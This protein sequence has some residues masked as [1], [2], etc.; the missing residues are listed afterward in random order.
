[1]ATADVGNMLLVSGRLVANPTNLAIA[2][3]FGGVELGLVKDVILKPTQAYDVL[4]EEAL[5]TEIMDVIDLGQAWRMTVAAR[6]FDPDLLSTVFPL[7]SEVGPTSTD[8][9][10]FYPVKSD[11]TIYR[12]GTLRSANGVKLLFVPD[13]RDRHPAVLLYNALPFV[14]EDA[15]LKCQLGDEFLIP[16]T[17]FGI[18]DG[19]SRVMQMKRLEDLTL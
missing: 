7:N 8:R 14:I 9:G 1:M 18:R 16:T 3:P 17:F 15:E 4:T 12:A 6:G 5:G 11:G 10:V 13:D 2:F 19:S